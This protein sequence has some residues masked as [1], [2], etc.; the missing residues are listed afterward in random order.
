MASSMTRI[1]GGARGIA[2]AHSGLLFEYKGRPKRLHVET[3]EP[4]L[5]F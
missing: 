3:R 5:R 2:L 1:L 4:K